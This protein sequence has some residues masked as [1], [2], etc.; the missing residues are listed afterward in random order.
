M[1]LNDLTRISTSGI[2]TGSTIDSPILRKDVSLRGSQ[3]GVTSVLFDSSD[4][5]LE[6]NDNVKIKLGNN[7]DL[8]LTHDGT[9]SIIDNNTGDLLIKTTG[10]G[11]DIIS[12]A[13]DDFIVYTA[14]GKHAI[15]AIGDGQVELWFDNDKK[16]E[17]TN[18]GAV[19]TGILTATSFSGPLI[20]SPINN[21]SG[22]STF[23]DLKVTNNLTVEGTTTTLD[24]NLIGV[25][26]VEVGAN[27][28]TVVGVA[29]TQSGTAD[30]LNLYDGSTEVLTVTDGGKVGIGTESPST[31]LDLQGD[32]TIRNGAEQNAIRT[33]SAGKLQFLRNGAVHNLVTLTIDDTDGNITALGRL[34]IG[35]DSANARLRVHNDSDD[36]AIIWVSGEDVTTEYLS[37]GIQPNKAILRGGGTGSTSTALAF[38]YSAAGT[39]TEG[40]RLDYTG[41]LGIGTISPETNLTIAKNATNQTVATIPTVR[42]TNLDTTAVATDIVGSYEFFSKDV[43]SN[44]KVTGFMRNT[45][46]DAGVNYDLTFGTIKTGDSD[47]V[48]R[49]RI[50]GSGQ[51]ELRKNQNG[52]TGRPDNRIVFKDTD[53]S[54]A[55]DQPIGEISWHSSDAGMTNVNSYIRGINEHTNG[56]GALLFGVKQAGSSEIEAMR[57][58]SLGRVGIGTDNPVEVLHVLQSGTTSADF[59]LE[60]SEGSILIR[61]DNNLAVYDAQQHIFRSRNGND[62]YGRFDDDGQ[63]GIGIASPGSVL[64]AY[65]AT[66]NTIAQFQSGDAGAGILLKDNTHYTR[67]E[68]TN[69][70]FKID[71]DAGSQI[72]S[73]VISFQISS[74]E[75]VRINSDGQIGIGTATLDTSADVSITNASSSARVYMKSADNADC[76]IY[77]GRMNDSATAAIRYDHDVDTLRFYGYNNSHKLYIDNN[78][79]IVA[80]SRLHATRTQAKFG[81]DCHELN[82]LDDVNDPSNY[83]MVFY[84]DP[85]TNLANGIGFFNDDGQSCGGYI[86]HQD[87]GGSNVGDIIF[88]TSASANTPVERLRIQSNGRIKFYEDPVQR[89]SGATDNFSGDGAYMQ[90]YVSRDGSTYRRNLDIA[91]V[92]DGTW[93]CSIRFSTNRDGSATSQERLRILKDGGVYL[94]TQSGFTKENGT[95]SNG[96]GYDNR[97]RLRPYWVSETGACRFHFSATANSGISQPRFWLFT[98]GTNHLTGKIEIGMNQRTNSPNNAR[99]RN[100]QS[101]WQVAMYGEG[102]NDGSGMRYNHQVGTQRGSTT[103]S[104]YGDY[105]VATNSSDYGTNDNQYQ[106]GYGGWY[107]KFD[108]GSGVQA[109]RFHFD[110]YFS[111]GGF[112]T[113]YMYIDQ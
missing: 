19:V 17:T 80:A 56:N 54:V 93:G 66:L 27:S 29:I 7:G 74:S 61:S 6:F 87:K 25:D 45:P 31:T 51:L 37:L 35:T 89:N 3:V 96:V 38:E 55:G 48:E 90:H 69:G 26:R 58:S 44:N 39:E 12:T 100:H 21:P 57:I 111:A 28:N 41:R 79:V 76:S 53:T 11:D 106:N 50:T 13:A 83:G 78:S 43:H 107:W 99:F 95:L 82:V 72:G 9:N 60:N 101:T 65:H 81:I 67:L 110:C 32:I 15:H 40:M 47:A 23:Y 22:I 42:L 105:Y 34:G 20:G 108:G 92:G 62:E 112:N 91:A 77:F 73:E 97:T 70:T 8:E 46:T 4:D 16:I 36:S 88:A 103:T 30:I 68:S 85:A 18:D 86:I 94:R 2:A 59:R 64:H 49:V 14:G 5:A 84:N 113:W 24:T 71:V 104:T 1:A 109:H 52:V 102:D 33:S 75:K 98:N 63:I 10:S